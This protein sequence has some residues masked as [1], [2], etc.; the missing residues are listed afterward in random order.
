[1]IFMYQ[2]VEGYPT[3]FFKVTFYTRTIPGLVVCFQAVKTKSMVPC[4]F[5]PFLLVLRLKDRTKGNRVFVL[6]N[7]TPLFT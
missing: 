5:S 1:M 6:A 7:D 2:G 3:P 4:N